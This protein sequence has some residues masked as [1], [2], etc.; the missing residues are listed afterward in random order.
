M[1]TDGDDTRTGEPDVL[2]HEQLRAQTD[3]IR[4]AW[5]ETSEGTAPTKRAK[6]KLRDQ[7]REY[8]G[9]A[10][11]TL[12]HACMAGD[13]TASRVNAAR[14]LLDRGYGKAKEIIELDSRDDD[15]AQV[16]VELRALRCNPATATALLT[17]A[18]ASAKLGSTPRD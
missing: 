3:R 17:L 8:T 2:A 12:V 16:V 4:I 13:T 11:A 10:I 6:R 9:L 7:V 14:E 5:S 1:G 18:E 15:A